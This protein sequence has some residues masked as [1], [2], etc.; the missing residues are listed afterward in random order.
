MKSSYINIENFAI[1]NI[2]IISTVQRYKNIY[3]I[4][5]CLLKFIFKRRIIFNKYK[6]KTIAKPIYINGSVKFEKLIK[7]VT[8]NKKIPAD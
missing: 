6:P 1:Y 8:G 7:I 5:R 2:G 3:K 4:L